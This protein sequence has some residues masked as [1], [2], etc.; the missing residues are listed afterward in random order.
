MTEAPNPT[1]P[2]RWERLTRYATNLAQVMELSAVE[3]LRAETASLERRIA[4][5][6][7]AVA[8][9][10]EVGSMREAGKSGARR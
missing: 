7:A 4:E 2:T 5:I 10:S 1:S 6:E 8:A 3:I 9:P